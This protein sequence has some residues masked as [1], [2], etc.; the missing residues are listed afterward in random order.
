MAQSVPP[1]KSSTGRSPAARVGGAFGVVMAALVCSALVATAPALA[2][3]R[4]GSTGVVGP[5]IPKRASASSSQSAV[6]RAPAR[7]KTSAKQT[8]TARVS[9]LSIGSRGAA[10]ADLQTRLQALRY[11]I[12]DTS[13]VFGDQTHHAVMAFQKVSG[14]S[15]S[16]VAGAQTVAALASAGAPEPLLPDGGAN[17][18]EID[19]KRQILM[20]YRDGALARILSVSSGSGK[21]FCVMDPETGKNACD[22]ANTPGG[23]F[24]ISRRWIG[25]RE[26][27]LGELYNPLYFNGGIAIHGAPSVPGYP[28]S[29]GCVRIPMISAEWFPNEVA[30]GTAVYVFGADKG[31]VPLGAKAPTD[32]QAGVTSPTT[33]PGGGAPP[34]ASTTPVSTIV[35][36]LTSTTIAPA[37]TV[38]PATVAPVT[39]A[40]TTAAPV[41]TQ[42]PVV[43]LAPTSTAAPVS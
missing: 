27:K 7:A 11:D 37:S 32:S 38:A 3:P 20:L 17:R 4:P 23:S 5:T 40:P 8:R 16:G 13:G 33:N 34:G 25:W 22:T 1:P 14:L 24:R 10:V 35:R 36:L 12:S 30:N 43:I 42:P 39:V 31:P 21:D 28:A 29:H 6:V 26:S 15:R 41:A 18:I 9:G 19:L 2:D